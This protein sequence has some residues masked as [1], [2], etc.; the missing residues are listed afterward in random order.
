MTADDYDLQR[1]GWLDKPGE[2]TVTLDN[3]FG[4]F[5]T[6]V[7]G[8]SNQGHT[9]GAELGEE[10]QRALLEYLKTL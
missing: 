2:V 10:A 5:D 1:V 8:N 3:G 7:R 6:S 9:Y 4:R